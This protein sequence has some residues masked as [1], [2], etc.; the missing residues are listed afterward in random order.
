M[1]ARDRTCHHP[2]LE[3]C[4]VN[5][6]LGQQVLPVVWD[7]FRVKLPVL[8]QPNVRHVLQPGCI[9]SLQSPW[10][11]ADSSS[12][13]KSVGKEIIDLSNLGALSA[14][15]LFLVFLRLELELEL[16]LTGREV[17]V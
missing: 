3:L 6:S 5:P 16:V 17:G 2:H 1:P 11:Q 12:T 14:F 13:L 9:L 10:Q 4:D 7:G 8:V 15:L